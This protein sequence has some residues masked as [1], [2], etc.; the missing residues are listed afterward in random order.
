VP[1]DQVLGQY[2]SAALSQVDRAD[3]PE[4]ERQLVQQYFNNL[5]K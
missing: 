4:Q 3:I 2:Q 5:S 1:Y